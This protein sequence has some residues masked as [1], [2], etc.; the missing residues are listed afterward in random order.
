[1]AR[2]AGV[3]GVSVDT[4]ADLADA[5]RA[6]I[7]AGKPYLIDANIGAEANP[8][9]AGVW[10]LPGMGTSQPGFGERYKPE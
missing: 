10:E 4:P 1:M 5:V 6:G 3:E 2:S 9:G 7:A 8:M